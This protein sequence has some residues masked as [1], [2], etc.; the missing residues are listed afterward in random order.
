M[1]QNDELFYVVFVGLKLTNPSPT[2]IHGTPLLKGHFSRS[3]ECPLNRGSSVV[4]A[5]VVQKVD[6][7]I[8]WINLSIN[9]I[10]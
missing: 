7:A 8:R 9:W 1:S 4:Q 2:S 10:T 6:S 3:R 5:P